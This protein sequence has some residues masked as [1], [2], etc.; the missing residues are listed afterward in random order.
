MTAK[1]YLNQI[2]KLEAQIRMYDEGIR[3]AREEL[4]TLRSPWPDGQPHG[5]GDKSDPVGEQ[6][7]KLADILMRLEEEQ[8]KTRTKLWLRRMEIIE[9]I[10]KMDDGILVSVLFS[11]YVDCKAWEQIAVDMGYSYRHIVRLHGEALA[12]FKK[13]MQT[14]P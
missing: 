2:R 4:V 5:S 8:L 3:K 10:G 14:C 9:Q 13:I 7:A 11:R 1:E 12:K 6:A